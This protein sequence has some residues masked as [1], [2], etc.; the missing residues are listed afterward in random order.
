MNVEASA[1]SGVDAN[2]DNDKVID[3]NSDDGGALL[4]DDVDQFSSFFLPLH[5]RKKNI[6]FIKFE[7]IWRGSS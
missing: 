2:M 3:K 1:N 6:Q 7:I 4:N 5:K